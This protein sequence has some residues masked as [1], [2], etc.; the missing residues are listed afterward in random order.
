MKR[1]LYI[2]I[3]A[4][5]TM[6]GFSSCKDEDIIYDDPFAISSSDVIFD[7]NGGTGTI[8]VSSSSAIT[9]TSASDW[10][11]VSVS[12]N[13]VT[14]T[15]DKNYS[16]NG[17]ASRIT[18]KSGNETTYVTAQQRGIEFTYADQ[19]YLV[20]MAGGTLD[21]VGKST[22]P[23]E[24]VCDADWVKIQ[25]VDG[26]YMLTIPFNDSGDSRSTTLIIQT[27]DMKSEYT[28]KQK[29]ERN[30]SGTYDFMFYK[31]V[32][33]TDAN[34]VNCTAV[35]TRDA[36]DETKYY[37]E[38]QDPNSTVLDDVKIPVT[39][40]Q[41]QELLV[42]PNGT[43]V[44]QHT[45]G[46]YKYICVN[47]TNGASNYYSVGTG[48]NYYVYFS[49]KMVDGKYQLSLFDSGAWFN[50]I[51]QGFGVYT[52]T[53]APDVALATANKKSTLRQY[54]YFTLTQK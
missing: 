44:G 26:G 52:F 23:V 19:T 38:V 15:A 45:D 40:D 1:I 37:L 11:T 49:Y 10:A 27:G 32:S 12:G 36:T 2:A 4:S 13:T 7:A 48:T 16:A 46:N 6:L 8:K 5:L 33:K 14:V 41:T 29:F 35:I 18:I 39:F 17:R 24:C 22:F 34:I 42:I 50:R 28:I 3:L 30:F 47:Y 21:I 9:A 43:Y 51:S 31:S 53:T 20:E 54:E 25:E